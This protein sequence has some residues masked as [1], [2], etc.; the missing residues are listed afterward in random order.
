[1]FECKRTGA[2]DTISAALP[3]IQDHHDDFQRV[4]DA[5]FGHGQPRIV[6]DLRSTPLIDSHGLE[7]ILSLRDRCQR[8]GGTVVIARPNPLC[9]DILRING[10]NRELN[11][12]EDYVEALGSFSR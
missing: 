6:L 4:V 1:M 7:S 12:F 5:C 2:V 11:I 3:I 9:S 8:L 10:L